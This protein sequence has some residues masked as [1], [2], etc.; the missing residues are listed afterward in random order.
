M[1][2]HKTIR[3]KPKL[4]KQLNEIA[5]REG[6][7]FTKVVEHLLEVALVE[8]KETLG[9]SLIDSAVN[10]IL[11]RHFKTLGDRLSRLLA[12]TLIESMT[13]RVLMLQLLGHHLGEDKA[14]AFNE[15]AY[16][17]AIKNM[18]KPVQELE[19]VIQNVAGKNTNFD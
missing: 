15:L 2:V 11:T 3:I 10:R 6:S 4:E 14:R 19:E 7:S 13:N 18:K 8:K 5:E 16:Q 12:R 17:N 9:V 1:K